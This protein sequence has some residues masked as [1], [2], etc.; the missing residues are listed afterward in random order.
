MLLPELRARADAREKRRHRVRVDNRV[1]H[2]VVVVRNLGERDRCLL[3]QADLEG[4]VFL[5]LEPVHRLESDHVLHGKTNQM[6]VIEH[7]DQL[8]DGACDVHLRTSLCLKAHLT[9]ATGREVSS[10]V[11]RSIL[12]RQ[13]REQARRHFRRADSSRTEQLS[14]R[15][16][17]PRVGDLVAV[18]RDQS[19]LC[20]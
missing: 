8:L 6:R 20:K 1:L 14:G 19:Q 10:R 11:N 4:W 18:A 7:R 15:L 9:R 17:A 12:V 2:V 5:L 13:V 3:L 16:D